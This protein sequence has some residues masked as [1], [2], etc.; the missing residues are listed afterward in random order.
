MKK[1]LITVMAGL[2]L[3]LVCFSTAFGATT[4][5]AGDICTPLNPQKVASLFDRWNNSLQTKDSN[6][7]AANYAAD[8][9][10][11]PTISNRPRTNH[12]EIISYFNNF[13]KANPVGTINQ[14]V[15][16]YGSD[17]ASDTGLYTFTLTENGKSR[18]VRARYS[19]VY[20]CIDGQWL[21]VHHHSSM[22]PK[23][24]SE[25]EDD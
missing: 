20:E 10:L 4:A 11:L 24:E 1:S 12:K 22:M 15:I 9:I 17:W 13:L 2:I 19:F 5:H 21:I 3:N 18:Q 6:K 23:A 14:R 7:V 16:R 25:E 8:A